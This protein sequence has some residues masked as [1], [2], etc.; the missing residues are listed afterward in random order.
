MESK[1][2]NLELGLT[3]ENKRVHMQRLRTFEMKHL[4]IVLAT[5]FSANA[6][7]APN[8]DGTAASSKGCNF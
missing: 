8:S 6:R 5:H 3:I 2:L 4:K 1:A 7:T